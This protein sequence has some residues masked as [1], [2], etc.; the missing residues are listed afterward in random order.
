[1]G[2]LPRL[3][4]GLL[5]LTASCASDPMLPTP[6]QAYTLAEG[7]IPG[8]YIDR[9]LGPGEYIITFRADPATLWEDTLSYAHR[10]AAEL[11]PG[12]Y[13]TVSQQDVSADEQGASRSVGTRIG[14]TV[15]VKHR[16]GAV[17]H[18]PRAQ[19]QVRCS[20]SAQHRAGSIRWDH[21]GDL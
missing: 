3:T 9:P 14:N 12:G 11:C 15:I 21:H 6:Y 19:L 20:E 7:S 10:R 5:A 4:I 1:M 16:P 18:L 17:T 8:G 2:W 13:E